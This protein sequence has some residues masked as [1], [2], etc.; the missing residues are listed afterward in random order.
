MPHSAS[1][2]GERHSAWAKGDKISPTFRLFCLK[3]N[4]FRGYF[5]WEMFYII[6]YKAFC[7]IFG[8]L[9]G[10]F[11]QNESGH[12]ARRIMSGALPRPQG[13]DQCDQIRCEKTLPTDWA[14]FRPL[15]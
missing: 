13:G 9:L 4:K 3:V 14:K 11:F 2:D 8:V 10:D 7:A 5:F 1:N 15:G 6:I 12:P